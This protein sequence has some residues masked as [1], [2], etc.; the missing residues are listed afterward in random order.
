MPEMDGLDVL[1]HLQA[2]GTTAV[3]PVLLYT[4]AVDPRVRAEAE[5]LGARACVTK[6]GGFFNLYAN[7]EHHFPD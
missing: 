1:R 4:A 7:I 6:S 2:R 5:R 3:V